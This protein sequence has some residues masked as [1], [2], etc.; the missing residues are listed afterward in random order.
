MTKTKE[1]AK[2]K[3]VKPTAP[4]PR[5]I[6]LGPVDEVD[7]VTTLPR[8]SVTMTG[9]SDNCPACGNPRAGQCAACGN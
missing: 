5:V 8:H 4:E 7:V 3:P 9:V 2:S 6:P 1:P